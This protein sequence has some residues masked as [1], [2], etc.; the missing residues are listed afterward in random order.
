MVDG[1]PDENGDDLARVYLVIKD[2][3]RIVDGGHLAVPR[4]TSDKSWKSAA[5]PAEMKSAAP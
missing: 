1:K 3:F 2:G 5:A 4:H